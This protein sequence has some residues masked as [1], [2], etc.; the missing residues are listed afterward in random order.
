MKKNIITS[1]L[2]SFFYVLLG[3][4]V[5]VVSFPKYQIFGFDYN[6]PLWLPLVIITLPV[7]ILLFGLVMVDF[8]IF[9]ILILQGIILLLCWIVIYFILKN[10]KNK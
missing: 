6:H 5:V 7:N 3:T 9:Y 8:S 2:I 4:I 10:I 1:F